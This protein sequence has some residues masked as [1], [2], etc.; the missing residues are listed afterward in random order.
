MISLDGKSRTFQEKL[1]KQS[2][3]YY[4]KTIIVRGITYGLGVVRKMRRI[5]NWPVHTLGLFQQNYIPNLELACTGDNC[6]G[7]FP[8]G[9]ASPADFAALA[10][11]IPR[12]LFSLGLVRRRSVTHFHE[13]HSMGRQHMQLSVQR[14]DD[15]TKKVGNPGPSQLWRAEAPIW[16]RLCV[17][18]LKVPM[19]K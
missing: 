15:D 14:A 5:Y 7:S 9:K 12:R 19:A 10:P 13:H 17:S 18:I 3:P 6:I 2:G 11:S 4:V 16:L 8:L 1:T